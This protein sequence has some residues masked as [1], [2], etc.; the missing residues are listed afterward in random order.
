IIGVISAVLI[1]G[2]LV[3]C[4]VPSGSKLNNFDYTAINCRKH[5]AILTDFG[6]VG[7]GKT[8]NTKAFNSAI[9]K[10]SQ[11]ANDGGALLIVPPGKWLTGSFNLTSH[12][13]LF[14]QKDA[15]ILG[16]QDEADWPELPV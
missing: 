5:S 1:F 12:F 2:S 7:D 3:E 8:L 4:R 11:Y 16:S 14:L 15:V 9:T 10:L 6:A 13:T